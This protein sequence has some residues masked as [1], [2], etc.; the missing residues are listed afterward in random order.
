MAFGEE[1]QNRSLTPI[2]TS[3]S[4]SGAGVPPF[5]SAVTD[6]KEKDMTAGTFSEQ[7]FDVLK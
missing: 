7:C 3:C 1:K 2:I 4:H 5:L 6:R